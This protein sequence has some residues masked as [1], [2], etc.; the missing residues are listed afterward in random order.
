MDCLFENG[1]IYE[2]QNYSALVVTHYKRKKQSEFSAGHLS[3]WSVTDVCDSRPWWARW[4]KTSMTSLGRQNASTQ[5]TLCVSHARIH[6]LVARFIKRI[7]LRYSRMSGE[8]FI[9]L[10][11]GR[12]ADSQWW[13]ILGELIGSAEYLSTSASQKTLIKLFLNR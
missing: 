8:P 11:F 13:A 1:N 12:N 3:R 5:A 6:S 7:F 4:G 9:C 10:S 2:L